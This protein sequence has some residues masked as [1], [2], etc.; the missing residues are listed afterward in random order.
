M[1]G[2][3]IISPGRGIIDPRDGFG[4]T[5]LHLCAESPRLTKL[6][7][8]FGA[9]TGA[10]DLSG[11]TPSDYASA[12]VRELLAKA[13]AMF[14]SHSD[15]AAAGTYKR[16]PDEATGK[17]L[18]AHVKAPELELR[19]KQGYFPKNNVSDLG[20]IRINRKNRKP[21]QR[22]QQPHWYRIV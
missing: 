9:D 15:R 4:Q 6:L 8:A 2:L 10:K 18:L 16:W 5:P 17:D 12:D 3:S 20:F 7:I 13:E 19:P 21:S 14:Q 1:E 22:N 11:K